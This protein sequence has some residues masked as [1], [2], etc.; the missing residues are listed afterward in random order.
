MSDGVTEKHI[1]LFSKTQIFYEQILQ[2]FA[3]AIGIVCVLVVQ[4]F[5][6]F[7]DELALS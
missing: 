3:R 6:F 4:T 1:S 7:A 5:L 2:V